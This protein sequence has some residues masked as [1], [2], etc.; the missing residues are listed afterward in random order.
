MLEL[1]ADDDFATR[2]ATSPVGDT[3]TS[4]T[5]FFSDRQSESMAFV[6]SVASR[7]KQLTENTIGQ[8][9]FDNILSFYGYGGVGKTKLSEAREDTKMSQPLA[10]PG[11][12]RR[13]RC[14]SS[15]TRTDGGLS[16]RRARA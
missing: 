10:F 14:G 3:T 6:E 1:N 5:E 16:I 9:S 11:A 15:A 7:D 2:R 8:G 4:A 12:T 13:S